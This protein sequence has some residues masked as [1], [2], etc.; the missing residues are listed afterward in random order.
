MLFNLL[1]NWKKIFFSF[2]KIVKSNEII[3]KK[4]VWCLTNLSENF[5]N[6]FYELKGYLWMCWISQ[7]GK[8]MIT[9]FGLVLWYDLQP[10][11]FGL[12]TFG[13]NSKCTQW[14]DQGNINLMNMG[15]ILEVL[16]NLRFIVSSN[17]LYRYDFILLFFMWSIKF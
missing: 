14:K 7:W 3:K 11:L 4:K 13:N 9:Y 12:S 16:G 2:H 17:V 1:C 15:F 8:G 5:F 10:F 6:Y